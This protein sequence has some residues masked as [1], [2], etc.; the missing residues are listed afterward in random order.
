MCARASHTS[1]AHTCENLYRVLQLGP[2]APPIFLL[3]LLLLCLL[4]ARVTPIAARPVLSWGPAWVRA[5]RSIPLRHAN[6]TQ[7]QLSDTKVI[8]LD[9]TVNTW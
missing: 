4:R 3:L 8:L 6:Q 1:H 2:K 9:M 5:T 7:K